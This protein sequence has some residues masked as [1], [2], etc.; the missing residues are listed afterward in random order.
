MLS[1]STYMWNIK[2][3]KT[4]NPNQLLNTK[5]K[6]VVPREKRGRRRDEIDEGN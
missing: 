3:N 6:L 5:N 4:K 1:D 2:Q